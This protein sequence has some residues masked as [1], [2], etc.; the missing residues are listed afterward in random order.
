MKTIF[1]LI[2]I[3]FVCIPA[4]SQNITNTIATNGTFTIKD[5]TTNFFTLTQST[6]LVNIFRNLRLEHTT[7]TNIGII[8]KGGTPFLHDFGAI[9]NTFLGAN[10]GNFTLSGIYNTGVG[11]N[12]FMNLST[13]HDNCAF[14][15][16]ALF[17]NN[18]GFDNCAFGV[19]SLRNN[20]SATWNSAFGYQSLY[21]NTTGFGNSAFGWQALYD[22]TTADWNT[23]FGYS[24]L[25][26]STSSYNSAFGFGALLYVT[27]GNNNIGIGA[28]ANVPSGTSS[29]QIRLGYTGITY[30]GIQVA[31][32][33]TSDRRWK[34]NILPSNLGLNFIS[35][36]NP[37]YYTRINDEKQNPE[38][39]FIGQEVDS[40]LRECN[41]DPSGMITITDEG[42][43]ELRYN[44]LFA[45][46]VKAIQELKMENEQLK[47]DLNE[48]R[49]LNERLT[50][51]EQYILD[52]KVNNGML[53]VSDKK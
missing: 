46:L 3:T 12:A 19:S 42:K 2:F 10:T 27:T 6:G 22:N 15:V 8:T 35:K 39:G 51:L 47:Q 33:I 11:S 1:I 34:Q 49:T 7:A 50:A 26:S 20:T 28:G 31:W 38:Y 24:A 17:A 30:A 16:S 21:N 43:Y 4:F 40:L 37:V 25:S 45:P 29:N 32:T 14:G 48:L 13:G 23:A 44:D 9:T 5:G 52:N 41:V 18:T 36:L 53:E